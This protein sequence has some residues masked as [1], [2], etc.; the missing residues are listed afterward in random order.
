[1]KPGK[2]PFEFMRLADHLSHP[3]ILLPPQSPGKLP[4]ESQN[5]KWFASRQ[6]RKKV[7]PQVTKTSENFDQFPLQAKQDFELADER[8]RKRLNSLGA[9][10]FWILYGIGLL[11][12]GAWVIWRA[13]VKIN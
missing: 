10:L 3:I 6:N 4:I 5:H 1:M 11:A 9:K 2:L 13:L 7:E 12:L 8:R